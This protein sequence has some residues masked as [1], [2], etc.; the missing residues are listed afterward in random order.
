MAFDLPGRNKDGKKNACFSI[1]NLFYLCSIH[2]GTSSTS[3]P[4]QSVSE[5]S[6]GYFS[7]GAGAVRKGDHSATMCMK[8]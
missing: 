6:I 2:L 8:V 3:V 4:M 5:K 7:E 1:A